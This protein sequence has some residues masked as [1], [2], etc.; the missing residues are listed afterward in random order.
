VLER[1]ADGFYSFVDPLLRTYIQHF[2]VIKIEDES[3]N[4][5]AEKTS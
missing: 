2:G 3:D 4:D 1:P 5:I